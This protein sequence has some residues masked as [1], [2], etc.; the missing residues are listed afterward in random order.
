[1]TTTAVRVRIEGRVQGVWF[2]G[3]T[4]QEARRLGLAGWVRNR[5]D[6]SVE[7]LF[8]G[9]RGAVEAMIVACHEGPSAAHVRSVQRFPAA[10]GELS[11]DG[12]AHLPTL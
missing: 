9:D 3:W 11:G 6:G 5:Q 12:F 8:A 7:A 4:I 10:A 1:V 2:R